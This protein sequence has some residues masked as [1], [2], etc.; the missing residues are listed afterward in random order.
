MQ[1]FRNHTQICGGYE[2]IKFLPTQK[3]KVFL[4]C[5]ISYLKIF[6]I[7]TEI[8]L[9]SNSKVIK[10]YHERLF[11]NLIC[12]RFWKFLI[13]HDCTTFFGLINHS[14]KL[15]LKDFCPSLSMRQ[16]LR[17]DNINSTKISQKQWVFLNQMK[18]LLNWKIYTLHTNLNVM[19]MNHENKIVARL[20]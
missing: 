18:I 7:Q 6:Y 13:L 2:K 19:K 10:I 12:L 3:K 1:K 20:L 16:H 15:I 17:F 9:K 4:S 5:F 8:A 14:Q 11:L